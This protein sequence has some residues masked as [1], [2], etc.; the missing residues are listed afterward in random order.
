M[1]TVTTDEAIAAIESA[2]QAAPGGAIAFDGDGTLW[3]GDVGEDF[4]AGFVAAAAAR[5]EAREALVREAAAENLPGHGSATEIAQRIHAAYLAHAFPE[6]RT[7]EIITWLAAGWP[8]TELARFCADVLVK[9]KL[10]SRLHGETAAILAHARKVGI[11]VYIV[12]ASPRTVVEEAAKIVGIENVVAVLESV[13][14][15]GVVGPAVVRPIPYGPGKVTRLRE[16]I[17]TRPLYAAFGDNAFDVP[18]LRE[19]THAFAVRPKQRLRDIES[20][21]P[22]LLE[23]SPIM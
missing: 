10:A 20:E 12:S 22:D 8:R 19:A 17:G 23:L 5:E 7:C 13:D 2:R 21:L 16:R 15:T 6:E 11:D 9:V 4:F 1:R 14:E 18:M 3:A